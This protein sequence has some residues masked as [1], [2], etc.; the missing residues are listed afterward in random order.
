LK[1]HHNDVQDKRKVRTARLRSLTL[2]VLVASAAACSLAVDLSGYS[3]GTLDAGSDGA[4]DD[5]AITTDDSATTDG[6]GYDAEAGD[7]TANESGADSGSDSGGDSILLD[8][9]DSADT[10]F[11]GG[12]TDSSSDGGVDAVSDSNDARVSDASDSGATDAIDAGDTSDT[13]PV[14]GG[15]CAVAGGFGLSELMI[16][17]TSGTADT[18]EW[19][20]LTNYTSCTLDVSNVFVAVTDVASTRASLTLPAGTLIAAGDSI[21]I[22][23]VVSVFHADAPSVPLSKVFDL[24]AT[25]GGI[26]TNTT[27]FT[28]VLRASGAASPYEQITFNSPP[29]T[30]DWPAGVSYAYPIP[31]TTCPVSAR[32]ATG[33]LPGAAWK[34]ALV[35]GGDK[36]GSVSVEAGVFGLYGTPGAPNT[37]VA[38]P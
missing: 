30:P 25:G 4:S 20:E 34:D 22:A 8:A 12:A 38:C 6:S 32:I 3:G 5:S 35:G 15:P 23:D 7:D 9:S 1:H 26:L 21:V 18:H 2:V 13:G 11:D 19:F 16:R 33:N 17:A 31:S 27:A 28:I 24:A 37:G 14:D 36:Y 29:R 10:S